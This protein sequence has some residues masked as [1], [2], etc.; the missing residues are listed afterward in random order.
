MAT[1]PRKLGGVLTYEFRYL[2]NGAR[3][4]ARY[5]RKPVRGIPAYD[6]IRLRFM[7][8]KPPGRPGAFDVYMRPDEAVAVAGVLMTAV[9]TAIEPS[10]RRR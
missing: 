3:I 4:S 6:S 2:G 9:W 8:K 1:A 10:R 5:R 7:R